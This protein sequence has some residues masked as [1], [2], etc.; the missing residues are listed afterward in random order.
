MSLGSLRLYGLY[1]EHRLAHVT[2]RIE[3]VNDKNAGLEERYSSLLSP[4]R[5]YSYA[6]SVLNM[7]AASEIETIRIGAE[8]EVMTAAGADR[9]GNVDSPGRIARLF[10]GLADAKD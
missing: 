9:R 6:H 1:L 2:A 3:A 8:P 5:I 7:V 10:T 4:S